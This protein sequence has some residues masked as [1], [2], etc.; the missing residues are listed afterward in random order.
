MRRK[1][2]QLKTLA[3]RMAHRFGFFGLMGR[4]AWHLVLLLSVFYFVTWPS[5]HL[6][7]SI[8]PHSMGL[9]R[10]NTWLSRYGPFEKFKTPCDDFACPNRRAS[11]SPTICRNT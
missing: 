1:F 6:D 8:H 9:Y 5:F 2:G 11:G 10:T 4:D 3:P 7:L